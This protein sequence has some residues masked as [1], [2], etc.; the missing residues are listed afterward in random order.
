MVFGYVIYFYFD[1]FYE[2]DFEECGFYWVIW[3]IDIWKVFGYVFS[4]IYKNVDI[5]GNG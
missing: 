1:Y 3:F 2:L 4:D 5:V